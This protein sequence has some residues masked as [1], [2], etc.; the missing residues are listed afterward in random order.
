M[1]TPLYRMGVWSTV[2]SLSTS[3]LKSLGCGAVDTEDEISVQ[4]SW[5]LS[6]GKGKDRHFSQRSWIRIIERICHWSQRKRRLTSDSPWLV[7]EPMGLHYT[8]LW[9]STFPS[10]GFA[11]NKSTTTL[12]G[13]LPPTFSASV[14]CIIDSSSARLKVLSVIRPTCTTLLMSLL[15]GPEQ[16]VI[17]S[18]KEISRKGR[19]IYEGRLAVLWDSQPHE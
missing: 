2:I 13:V 6:T 15:Y 14:M 10:E 9:L 3:W 16:M 5:S 17:L 7:F 11:R 4:A 1:K 19:T 18:V 8:R 12:L